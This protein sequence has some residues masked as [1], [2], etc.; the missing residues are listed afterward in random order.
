MRR[1]QRKCPC[2]RAKPEFPRLAARLLAGP[3][4]DWRKRPPTRGRMIS[5]SVRHAT[6]CR[7]VEGLRRAGLRVLPQL[8]LRGGD[9]AAARGSR[10]RPQTGPPGSLAREDRAPRTAFAAHT[11]S[12]MFSLLARHPRLVQPLRQLFGEDVYVHQFKLNAKAPFA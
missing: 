2:R 7:P 1:G 12:E 9:R 6:V 8:L 3:P 4:A 10:E 11:F 5:G